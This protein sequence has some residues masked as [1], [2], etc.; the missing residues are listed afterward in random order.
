MALAL[1]FLSVGAILPLLPRLDPPL[2]VWGM[3]LENQSL[4]L[5]AVAGVVFAF[6][7]MFNVTRKNVRYATAQLALE[8]IVMETHTKW[9]RIRA[10]AANDKVCDKHF[11]EALAIIHCYADAI[12]DR[13]ENETAE[14]GNTTLRELDRFERRLQQE[15]ESIQEQQKVAQ[16]S[17]GRE[18]EL[19][20]S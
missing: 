17:T 20:S 19:L 6:N 2:Q 12:Y 15:R 7:Q 14:W 3:P 11:A 9:C 4:L 16:E 5:F 13:I 18:G 8:R 10:A 1:S